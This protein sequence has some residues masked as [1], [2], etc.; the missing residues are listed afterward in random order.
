MCK[1]RRIAV[2]LVSAVLIFLGDSARA[3]TT[4]LWNVFDGN[5]STAGNWSPSGVPGAGDTVNIFGTDGVSRTITYDYTG[6]AVTLGSLAIDLTNGTPTDTETLSMSANNLTAGF[7]YVGYSGLGSNGSGTFNQ[8][9]GVNTITVTNLYL[10]LN[11]TDTGYYN[12]SGTGSVVNSGSSGEIVGYSGTGYF[13]QSGGSNSITANGSALYLGYNSNSTGTYTLN[14]GSITMGTVGVIANQFVGYGTGSS[15]TF[16][17][18]GGTNNVFNG[19]ASLYLAYSSNSSGSY[20]LAAGALNT[21][22][23]Y[24]GFGGTGIFTQTGGTNTSGAVGG[25]SIGQSAGSTGSYTMSGG[26]LSSASAE[27]V[28]N[29]GNGTFNQSGG[30]NITTAGVDPVYLGYS[31]TAG[32]VGTYYLSGTGALSPGGSEYVG[33][34]SEGDFYQSGGTN[35]LSLTLYVGYSSGVNGTYTLSGTGILI[36]HANETIGQG[37]V[38][39]FNQTGGVNTLTGTNSINLGSSL[40]ASGTYNLSGGSAT[41]G[42]NVNLGITTSVGVGV[43]NVSGG[44]LNVAGTIFV[45]NVP[46]SAINLSGGAINTA[47][48][49]L[50]NNP[51]AL[52]WTGGTLDI[53]TNLTLDSLAAGTSTGGAFGPSLTLV[54]GQTLMV[55]GNE[56]VGGSG[57]FMLTLGSGAAHVVTGTLTLTSTGVIEQDDGSTLDAATF[58]QAGGAVTGTLQNQGTFTYQSGVFSGRLLNQ[59]TVNLGLNFTAGD[60]V[61]NDTSMTLA[62]GQTLTANGDGINNLGSFVLTG[63]TVAGN[64]SFLNN[65]GGT[66]QG[67]G[68]INSIVNNFG[69]VTVSGVLAFNGGILNDGLI[70]GS[71]TLSGALTNNADGTI[72]LAAGSSLAISTAWSSAG[73]IALEGSTAR[74]SGGGITNTGAVQGHG[75]VS[76]AIDNS[77]TVEALGGTLSLG[78][79]VQNEADGLLTAG[80]G[81]K[82]LVTAGLTTNAGVINLTGG[83]FDNNGHAL[84]NMGQISGWGLLRTGG[85]GL[86]NNGSITFTGGTTTVNGPVTNENGQTITIAYNPAIFTGMVTNNNGA[87]FT[88]TSATATFAGGFTNNGATNFVNMAGGMANIIAAPTTLNTGSALSIAS[89]TVSF[90]LVAGSPVVGSGVSVV[91]NSGAT[92]QL[93]GTVSALSDSTNPTTNLANVITHGTGTLLVTGTNQSVGTA[94]GDASSNADGATV[95]TG[96]TVVGNGSAAQLTATQ[97]LQNTLTINAGSTVTIAPSG[98]GMSAVAAGDS[99]PASG[100]PIVSGEAL[101]VGSSGGSTDSSDPFVAIQVAIQSGAISSAAGK[102]LENRLAAT[103]RLGATDPSLDVSLLESRILAAI[104]SSSIMP[105][106]D[107]SSL[108]ETNSELLAAGRSDF[109]PSSTDA[110]AAFAPTTGLSGSPAAVPEPPTLLL[111]ALAVIGLGVARMLN[112]GESSYRAGPIRS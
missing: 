28:G 29:Q 54:N 78:G 70:Q 91:V 94:T 52:N 51:A 58:I 112:S 24:V 20:T 23:E 75:L 1:S 39:V 44:T 110:T 47:A 100:A 103:E 77:G 62:A 38:G 7:E 86:D 57:F 13:T 27:Y 21:G 6:G 74:L 67:H 42:G 48:L 105:S 106:T 102:R 73:L 41:V 64:G 12:L 4:R 90:D 95:Y 43:L 46:G 89:G 3:A 111:A 108:G 5:W 76:S 68:A 98:A 83:T 84:N 10:G 14:S 96:S 53:T 17:Q 93:A 60:G 69:A 35:T 8:S 101:A 85:T 37:G 65:N 30:L 22:T 36:A 109:S 31:G 2:A 107:S 61:E 92:L 82:L 72:D 45:D 104:P 49:N 32:A 55:T 99:A 11:A 63:G 15:G 56:N 81:S 26:T 50:N 79:A 66:L 97:I 71:G 25:I 33:Y 16:T 34:G 18:N 19:S 80:S 40:V 88:T 59:G 87:T 9:G